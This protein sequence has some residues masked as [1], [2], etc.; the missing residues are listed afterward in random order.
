[1]TVTVKRSWVTLFAAS[2]LALGAGHHPAGA[3]GVTQTNLTSD[4]SVA[5]TIT[6]THLVNAWGM[7]YS[8]TGNWWLSDNGTGLTT[9]YDGTGKPSPTAKPLV[10]TIPRPA[11][12]TTVAT[13]T[14]QV[15]NNTTGFVVHGATKSGAASF[16]FVTE[17]GTISGWNPTANATNAIIT[18]D[19]S[20]GGTGAVYKGC[21]LFTAG[22]VTNLLVANFRSGMVEVYDNTWTLV[23]SFRDTTLSANYGPFNV[24]VLGGKIY[25]SYAKK[26]PDGHDDA[27]GPGNGY[28]EQVNITGTVLRHVQNRGPLNSPWGMALA[29]ASWGSFAGALLVGNFGDGRITAF[30]LT[31]HLMIGQLTN[32]ASAPITIDGLWGIMP[33]NGSGAGSASAIYFT[34][35]PVGESHGLFGDLT[36]T[37]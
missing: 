14:G 5:G 22:G 13:P 7:S 36:F 23:R 32:S 21:A 1:M 3:T 37:P 26:L 34:A 12:Q 11:G 29:P 27:A 2:L 8:P 4:G 28:V 15:F 19:N 6:D 31:T 9:V 25:V 30:N 33:G 16:I 20:A 18:V 10:V 24:A 17:D 35:G